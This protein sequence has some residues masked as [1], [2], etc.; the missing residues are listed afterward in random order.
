[1]VGRRI[2]RPA[3]EGPGRH[4]DQLGEAGGERAQRRAADRHHAP[5]RLDDERLNLVATATP[6]L[7]HANTNIALAFAPA[8][9]RYLG[10]RRY[11]DDWITVATTALAICSQL[12]DRHGEAAALI[13]LGIAL[14]EVRRF[15]E[16]IDGLTQ[17]AT[18]CREFDDR[19]GE[20]GA[21]AHLGLA[22][23]EAG[24]FDDDAVGHYDGFF[25]GS[26]Q[27]ESTAFST[28]RHDTL[29]LRSSSRIFM[30]AR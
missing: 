12:G 2:R 23:V 7:G 30:P 24:R 13:S 17:A 6:P 18:V 14:T 29:Y 10:Y 25:R 28:V 1:M 26:G 21:L 27:T 5:P 3:P 11:F 19:H 4:A 9:A 16:A 22:L 8:L 20:A 15:D